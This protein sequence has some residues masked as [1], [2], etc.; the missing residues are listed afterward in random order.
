MKKKRRI[1]VWIFS[2]LAVLFLTAFLPQT[3]LKTEAAAKLSKTSLVL[4]KGEKYTL[5]VTGTSAKITWKS[6][7][8]TVATVSGGKITAKSP[9][10]AKITAK[11]KGKTLTCKLRVAEK[12]QV[13]AAFDFTESTAGS[14]KSS[15]AVAAVGVIGSKSAKLT[16][17]VELS[18]SG[19]QKMKLY[20]LDLSKMMNLSGD[21]FKIIYKK[22]QTVKPSKVEQMNIVTVAYANDK[23]HFYAPFKINRNSKI[24]LYF[25]Y[26]GI[27]YKTTVTYQ[28]KKLCKV[29]RISPY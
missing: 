18:T 19:Q 28:R 1:P 13:A 25:T 23:A 10:S 9:G 15:M 6:S 29:T 20:L 2:F 12:P 21:N 27:K 4:V 16:S 11:V 22:S 17:Y 5:K 14:G 24:V 7:N 8:K 3:A 26:D